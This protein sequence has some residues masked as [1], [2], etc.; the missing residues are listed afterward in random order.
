MRLL[1]TALLGL[2]AYAA[3]RWLAA[4]TYDFN[5]KHVL[6]TG[7]ARGLGLLIARELAGK[8][9]KLTICARSTD[10]LDGAL[11]ELSP[12][13]PTLAVP[14]DVTDQHQVDDLI[15]QARGRF[16]PIDVLVNN[17]GIIGVGPVE[18]M[19]LEDFDRAMKTHFWA[20][21]YTTLAVVPEMQR[22]R[23]GRIVNISSIGGKIAVPHMLPY[24]ASKF[25]LTG[26]SHGLRE[27]LA[28][29]GVV[30]TTVCPGVMRTGSHLHAEFKGRNEEEYRWFATA[31]GIPGF[32]V[33]ATS[34]ARAIVASC[35]RGDAELIISIPARI[36]VVLQTLMPGWF[37]DLNAL[38]NRFILPE[39]G[40]IGTARAKGYESRDATPSLLTALPDQAARENNE[41]NVAH[42]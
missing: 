26:L 31:S 14:C 5:G 28:R 39:P 22:R 40:G 8:G 17:A 18:E 25:A 30:V 15:A 21:L 34:A 3:Y 29:D 32:S 42:A 10:D 13:A 35:A 19:R 7:G 38:I 9:A 20:A 36:A 6:I 2:G 16:G 1:E 12:R 41:M 27:E 23:T 33:N 4:P 24:T 11:A 37:D